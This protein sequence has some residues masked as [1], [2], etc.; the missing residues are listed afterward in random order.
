[1]ALTL[2]TLTTACPLHA[3]QHF[4]HIGHPGD[5]TSVHTYNAGTPSAKREALTLTINHGDWLYI[6]SQQGYYWY[7]ADQ[8]QHQDVS[9]YNETNPANIAS[10][11][12]LPDDTYPLMYWGGEDGSTVQFT[13]SHLGGHGQVEITE[14][15]TDNITDQTAKIVA[16]RHDHDGNPAA[17]VVPVANPP[18]GKVIT[19]VR[20]VRANGQDD[21]HYGTDYTLWQPVDKNGNLTSAQTATIFYYSGA[22]LTNDEFNARIAASPIYVHDTDYDAL[23]DGP[24]KQGASYFY[25][26]DITFADPDGSNSETKHVFSAILKLFTENCFTQ[27]RRY[28]LVKVTADPQDNRYVTYNPH[29]A[30]VWNATLTPD[31][32]I[33]TYEARTEPFDYGA[34]GVRW[35]SKIV[36]ASFLPQ[37]FVGTPG[38]KAL[39]HCHFVQRSS[40]GEKPSLTVKDKSA[41]VQA[42]LASGGDPTGRI[43]T[44]FDCAPAQG[45]GAF[46]SDAL[47]A[48][49]G[50]EFAGTITSTDGNAAPYT[51]QGD[52][53]YEPFALTFGTPVLSAAAPAAALLEGTGDARFALIDAVGELPLTGEFADAATPRT[54]AGAKRYLYREDADITVLPVYPEAIAGPVSAEFNANGMQIGASSSLLRFTGTAGTG[55]YSSMGGSPLREAG[56]VALQYGSAEPSHINIYARALSGIE[57]PATTLADGSRTLGPDARVWRTWWQDPATGLYSQHFQ[58]AFIGMEQT[59]AE[60]LMAADTELLGFTPADADQLFLISWRITTADA[61]RTKVVTLPELA[62]TVLLEASEPCNWYDGMLE[63]DRVALDD[64]GNAPTSIDCVRV[65]PLYLFRKALTESASGSV[66]MQAPARADADAAAEFIPVLGT[67]VELASKPILTSAPVVAAPDACFRITPGGIEIMGSG[68]QVVSA[69]GITVATAPG[70]H[71]LPAGAYIVSSGAQKEKVMVR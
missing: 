8:R 28:Q 71:A 62:A 18:E 66:Q 13:W 10:N 33:A 56:S 61:W 70:F 44:V 67:P 42:M 55:S 23:S 1:M 49:Y 41:Q 60:K 30:N 36:A 63:T 29:A 54:A 57:L 37:K 24:L 3:E 58:L 64:R 7:L 6:T 40:A 65:Q 25:Y 39:T 31:G 34:P 32:Q 50:I 48:E 46:A 19:E 2:A 5:F 11:S 51:N 20:I 68:V 16:K 47:T 52:E 14:F 9:L 21:S 4:L 45:T 22:G 59:G 27:V 38:A 26:M 12:S 17:S 43:M 35:T 15:V 69:A 53:D